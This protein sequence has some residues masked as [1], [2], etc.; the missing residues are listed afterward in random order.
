MNDVNNGSVVQSPNSY[1]GAKYDDTKV[2]KLDIEL[3][4]NFPYV[5]TLIG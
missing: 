1:H 4:S 5:D 2:S 3:Y